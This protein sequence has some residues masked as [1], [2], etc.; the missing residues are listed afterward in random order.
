MARMAKRPTS[1][2]KPA[3]KHRHHDGRPCELRTLEHVIGFILTLEE[4]IMAVDARI[5]DA[6]AALDG[7]IADLSKKVDDF[8]ASHTANTEADVQAIVSKTTDEG[9][10]VD[11]I[12]AKLPA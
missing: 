2:R 7:K 9:A 3:A 4:Q 5:T 11:A 1:T 8:I 10:A 12:G 6:Q